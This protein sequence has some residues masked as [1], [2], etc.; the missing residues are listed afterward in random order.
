MSVEAIHQNDSSDE[1]EVNLS[2]AR[3]HLSDYAEKAKDGQT[4]YLT[5][6]GK[7]VAA[8]VPAD[9]AE[10]HADAEDAYWARRAREAEESGTVS[11]NEAI[12]A[13]EGGEA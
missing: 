4:V 2:T 5:N 12:V 3:P 13:L 8:L 7:R 1:I 9:V 10:A 11:W 6:R